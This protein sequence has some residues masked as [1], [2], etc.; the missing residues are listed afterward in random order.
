MDRIIE[1][2]DRTCEVMDRVI[3]TVDRIDKMREDRI[4]KGMD[5]II[6]IEH[7]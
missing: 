5:R 7:H 1:T 6:Q 4:G 3:K 2:V